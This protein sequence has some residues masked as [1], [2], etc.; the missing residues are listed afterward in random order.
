MVQKLGQI[1]QVNHLFS[2]RY[3]F[4]CNAFKIRYINRQYE[5]QRIHLFYSTPSCYGQA[6]RDADPKLP[7]KNDDFFPYSSDPHAYWTGYFTS[8]AAFKG[9]VRQ[10]S[11]LLQACKQHEVAQATG[12]GPSEDL[13]SLER[14]MAIAQH[15][16][17]ITG[18][19]KQHVS[20]DYVF[21]LDNG[22]RRCQGIISK[23]YGQLLSKTSAGAPQQQFCPFLN[24]SQCHV[25]EESQSFVVTLYNPLSFSVSHMVRLPVVSSDYVVMDGDQQLLPSQLVPIADSILKI[26]GRISQAKFELVFQA[27]DLPPMGIK[28]YYVKMEQRKKGT[29]NP[30]MHRSTVHAYF[31]PRSED[32]RVSLGD[33]V[34]KFDRLTGHLIEMVN[35]RGQVPLKQELL[36]YR[37]MAG[38]NTE[39]EYRASG[40]Y[41]F[42]P[43]GTAT[44][45]GPIEQLVTV[46]GPLMT[47]VYQ[48]FGNGM[49][50]I[51]RLN[52]G[53]D[54]L[55]VDW[56]VGPIP[57]DD[58]VGKEIISRFTARDIR[59]EAVF[60]TDSNGREVLERRLNYQPT[61]EVNVTEPIAANYYPVNAFAYIDDAN[62]DLRMVVLNDRAQG[63]SS[64]RDGELE[65]M[66][67]RVTVP[68]CH[69]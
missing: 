69:V 16:D 37:G 28:T 21:R 2:P 32:V 4:Y 31:F 58:G 47:Q 65:F 1:N 51:M 19:A 18:T 27:I 10:S 5:D 17:A 46:S 60:F 26:P 59:N 12:K 42:R 39:F 35:A 49:S 40:A 33:T 54:L 30:P 52:R 36:F 23:S 8:R 38:N 48:Q 11:N 6:V 45:V 41:I 20:N 24:M 3:Y 64:L 57:V 29:S 44:P 66:V 67:I 7:M 53:D 9:L 68:V 22:I 14:S 43:N 62:S 56:L 63:A 50:Q 15:H 61:Y 25:T 55:E 34:L 13:F